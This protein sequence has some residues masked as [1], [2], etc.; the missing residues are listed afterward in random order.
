VIGQAIADTRQLLDEH[1]HTISPTTMRFAT[2][3]ALSN[4]LTTGAIPTARPRVPALLSDP[5]LTGIS[6]PQLAQ[7]IERLSARQTAQTE[8]RLYRRRGEERLPGAR[9]GVFS[10]KI[11]DAERV[12]ATV[13]Y[14]R[15][16]CTR[17]V[18]AELFEVT[19]RTIDVAFSQIRPLLEQDGYI[20][21]PAPSRYSTA[22]ALL[23]SVT[24][25]NDHPEPAQ[26]PC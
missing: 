5:S 3:S 25:S 12:L 23:D 7:L 2:A 11:T 14:Q 13:L 20:A 24:P 18:L 15:Q 16:V 19:P 21:T 1:G 26:P 6:R 10:Q 8:R 4:F 17:K 9:R 22:A